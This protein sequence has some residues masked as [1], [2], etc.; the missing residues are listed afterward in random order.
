MKLTND[1]IDEIARYVSDEQT[2][3]YGTCLFSK[4]SIVRWIKE[5]VKEQNDYR[6]LRRTIKSRSDTAKDVRT[7]IRANPYDTLADIADKMN[8][9]VAWLK[10]LLE[11]YPG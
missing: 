11:E 2:E 7:L 3:E 9:S 1:L 10:R 6:R 8:K 5:C 4:E